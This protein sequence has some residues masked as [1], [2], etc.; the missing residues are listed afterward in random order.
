M[1]LFQD[2]TS[3][4]AEEAKEGNILQSNHITVVKSCIQDPSKGKVEHK[5]DT[6]KE[7]IVEEMLHKLSGYEGMNNK[8]NKN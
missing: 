8:V 1:C 7:D 2:K 6:L 5:I 3:K 4:S